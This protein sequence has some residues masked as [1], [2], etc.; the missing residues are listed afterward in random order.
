M[1]D[2]AP[3][4]K[5]KLTAEDT[6]VANAIK[7]LGTQLQTLKT[8]SKETADSFAGLTGAFDKLIASAVV[9]KIAEFGKEVFTASVNVE[10]MS[11]K[12]GLSA[13]LLSTFG[14]AAESSGIQSDQMDKALGRLAT[15]ITK[16][17]DGSSKATSSFKAHNP[18]SR[19]STRT[20][21]F[22]S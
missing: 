22:G 12:T 3:E 21:K 15:N 17:Q 5:I 20:R 8:Q 16:F 13:G 18:I 6:G 11:Q 19:V 4:V 1:A 10:R 7:A 2:S 9:L 14:K